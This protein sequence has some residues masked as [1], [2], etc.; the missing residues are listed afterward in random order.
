M[1]SRTP[2]LYSRIQ[3]ISFDPIPG[4]NFVSVVLTCKSLTHETIA[5]LSDDKGNMS[6]MVED[7][8]IQFLRNRGFACSR[9]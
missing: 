9:V 3:A 1:I 6:Q 7:A 8:C 4:D 2:P 5:F